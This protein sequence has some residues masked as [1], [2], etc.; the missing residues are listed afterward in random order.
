MNLVFSRSLGRCLLLLLI[1]VAI[2]GHA[3]SIRW[4]P[5]LR[6]PGTFFPAFTVAAATRDSKGPINRPEV[7]GYFGSGSL[8]VKVY[9]AP[10]GTHIKV[11][12][13]IAAIGVSG[14]IETDVQLVGGKPKVIIP[15]LNWDQSRLIAIW[16]PI[17]SEAVFRVFLN[18]ALI[19]ED[20]QLVRIRAITDA[21]RQSCLEPNDCDDYSAFYAAFVNEDNPLIDQVL[22]EALNIPAMPVKAWTGTQGD[23]TSV[24]NQVWAI[25]YLLQRK[26]FTYSNIPTVADVR[27]EIFSQTVRPFSLALGTAQ[28]NCVD[29]TVF[30]A[31][32]LRK[33]GI[34]P[35]IVLTPD[36]AFLGFFTDTQLRRAVFLET[37]LL[38]DES[39]PFYRHEPSK[40]GSALSRFSAIDPHIAQSQRSFNEALVEGSRKYAEVAQNVGKGSYK[41]ISIK[42]ARESGILPLPL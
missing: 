42:K 33:I 39:N 22:R 38:N 7:Y 6:F 12:V 8:G 27:P 9:D 18:G 16:Q 32:I 28:A 20:R 4:E 35:L 23:E 19:R 30:F 1:L 40:L 37:T 10:K 13:E 2:S 31:S 41:V 24:L 15:R 21:P 29:G 26:K 11:Q 5:F 3:Q 36:H 14:E 17:S 25:W 34:E